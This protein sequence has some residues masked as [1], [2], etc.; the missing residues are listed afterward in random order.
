MARSEELIAISTFPSAAD[1]QIAKGILDE[2]RI[3]TEAGHSVA[4]ELPILLLLF[5]VPAA[6]FARW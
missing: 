6:V 3:V 5:P 1:A 2:V 4:E